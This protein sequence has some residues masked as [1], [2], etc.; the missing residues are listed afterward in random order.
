MRLNQIKKVVFTSSS[1]VYGDVSV[2]LV[3]QDHG[4]LLPISLYGAS[5]LGAEGLIS[6]FCHG[7]ICGAGS[8][9]LLMLSAQGLPTVSF[10]NFINKLKQNR[11]RLEILGDGSQQSNKE[12]AGL[13]H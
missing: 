6:A 7:S 11:G 8:L 13:S 3:S 10:F 5:K 1:A 9:D 2:T 12:Y 4:P